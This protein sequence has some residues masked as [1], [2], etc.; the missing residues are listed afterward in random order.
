MYVERKI[1]D[2]SQDLLK[3]MIKT[4]PYMPKK[5][6]IAMAAEG[7]QRSLLHESEKTY[8]EA[9][10]EKNVM[11]FSYIKLR[12]KYE[13]GEGLFVPETYIGSLL[14]IGDDDSKEAKKAGTQ[15]ILK[16]GRIHRI[17]TG[18]EIPAQEGFQKFRGEL[19]DNMLESGYQFDEGSLW[20][21]SIDWHRTSGL[22]FGRTVV[23]LDG[24][25]PSKERR[26]ILKWFDNLQKK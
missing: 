6:D 25:L 15:G 7:I 14:M 21:S 22:S 8:I 1:S 18:I 4:L 3:K 19:L 12:Y 20:F 17:I 10:L 2:A 13:K 23:Q 24:E 16:G 9:C 11:P 26:G 5:A